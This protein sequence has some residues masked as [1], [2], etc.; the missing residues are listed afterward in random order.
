MI[1]QT[2]LSLLLNKLEG[3]INILKQSQGQNELMERV[4]FL[5]TEFENKK[6][7]NQK[8]ASYITDL[9]NMLKESQEETD[10]LRNELSTISEN[11]SSNLIL[12]SFQVI[13]DILGDVQRVSI[14]SI[15]KSQMERD[16]NKI[17]GQKIKLEA[18]LQQSKIKI[19]E[20]EKIKLD[21][22]QIQVK[23][24]NIYDQKNDLHTE[25]FKV[26]EEKLKIQ[27]EFNETE[28][29][30]K[31]VTRE[32]RDQR[33][34]IE[35]LKDKISQYESDDAKA[36]VKSTFDKDISRKLEDLKDKNEELNQENVK[37]KTEGDQL[38]EKLIEV[39]HQVE[40]KLQKQREESE[41]LLNTYK[42]QNRS[43][44]VS[45]ENEQRLLASVITNL[46]YEA[47]KRFNTQVL[48]ETIDT[49]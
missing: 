23:L 28:S 10:N 32:S 4:L 40:I 7:D 33:R 27:S 31:S 17:K 43:S 49:M 30:L 21:R 8:Q 11:Q 26:K 45:Y 42:K 19:E 1:I 34:Q 39:E 35:D 22:D 18:E 16:Y 6:L 14:E 5:E 44:K 47:F 3:Q 25:I 46:G 24:Q 9:T 15:K 20:L 2:T 36:P 12:F 38:K 37:L 29:N 41:Y 13:F 48:E